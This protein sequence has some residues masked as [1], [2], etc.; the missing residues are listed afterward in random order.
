MFFSKEILEFQKKSFRVLTASL[1]AV[2]WSLFIEKVF[3]PMLDFFREN[4]IGFIK[5]ENKILLHIAT[6]SIKILFVFI[7]HKNYLLNF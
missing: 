6:F 1:A 5:N 2:H 4:E 7:F 3:R